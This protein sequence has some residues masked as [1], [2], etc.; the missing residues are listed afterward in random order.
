M[1]KLWDSMCNSYYEEL[2]FLIL[3]TSIP[4]QEKSQLTGKNVQMISTEFMKKEKQMAL[5]M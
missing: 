1:K 3:V 5:K 4:Q 2:I